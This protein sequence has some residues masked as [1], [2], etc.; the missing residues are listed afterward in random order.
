[1]T[2]QIFRN[3]NSRKNDKRKKKLKKLEDYHLEEKQFARLEIDTISIHRGTLY[4]Y[5]YYDYYC[6]QK[7]SP[8]THK[9]Y[10]GVKIE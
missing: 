7:S 1:M 9:F 3:I 8:N 10:L 2:N 5:I 6:P 4:I